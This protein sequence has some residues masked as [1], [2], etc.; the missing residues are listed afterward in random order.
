MAKIRASVSSPMTLR[1]NVNRT[2][3]TSNITKGEQGFGTMALLSNMSNSMAMPQ[4]S[5]MATATTGG[6]FGGT[7]N[8]SNSYEFS[9]PLYLDGKEVA[10]ATAI[11]NQAEL[12]KLEKRGRRKR[13][14]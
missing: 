7:V 9:I 12:N 13:G 2:I 10:K 4:P 8:N 6:S 3:T 5:T 1:V 14:E 11:Y